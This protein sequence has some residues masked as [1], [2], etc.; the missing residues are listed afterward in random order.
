MATAVGSVTKYKMLI[1]GEWIDASSRQTYD[2]M[3]PYTGQTWAQMP[4]AQAEDVDRAVQAARKAVKDPAWRGMVPAQRGALLRKLGDLVAE[5]AD[6]LGQ[7]ETRDNGK[8][9]REMSAQCKAV[10]SYFY[11]YAGLADKIQGATIPLEK[12]S[13]FNYTLREPIGVVGIIIPWNSPLLLLSFSLAAAL[14]AGNAV[15]A[16]PSEHASAST[17]EFAKLVEQASFPPGVFNVVTGYGAVTGSAMA[18][19]PG[20]GKL[21]FTGGPETARKIAEQAALNLTPTLLE[22]GG[23]SPNIVFPDADLQNAVNGT[24]AGIFAAG[25]QTCIAGSRLLLHEDIHDE[26]MERLVARTRDIKMGDPA[27]MESE[28]GPLA[29]TAQLAK[30]ES[31]VESARAEG[32]ELVYGGC[33]PDAPELAAGWFYMPTIFG[34]VHN[35]M[36]VAQEE[37]FGPVLGVLRFREEEEAVAMANDTR[38]GLAAG[39]WTDDI[40]RAHRLARDLDAGTV[41]INMYRALSYASP[42]GG[43]KGSGHGRELG[44]DAINEFTQVKSVW[45]ELAETTPDPFV[46]RI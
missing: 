1:G 23:K 32:A 25:G 4:D 2:S 33:R 38:Y 46:L 43:Y 19:H 30:V 31:F 14:A 7:I 15:V 26:F 45:V 28:L 13:V 9:I 41:W 42:F 22:L 5:N 44:I 29:T 39:I 36:Y 21:S 16:K 3:N 12:T 11:F 40:K 17:L 18:S 34:G 6:Y 27:A 20:I 35:D 24:I 37:V 8:L 10:P